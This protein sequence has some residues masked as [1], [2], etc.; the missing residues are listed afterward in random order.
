MYKVQND[1]DAMHEYITGIF[2][3]QIKRPTLQNDTHANAKLEE[4]GFNSRSKRLMRSKTNPWNKSGTTPKQVKYIQGPNWVPWERY[5]LKDQNGYQISDQKWIPNPTQVLSLN[6]PSNEAEL[7]LNQ[8]NLAKTKLEK[9]SR[10]NLMK[11][12]KINYKGG[13][14]QGN[15]TMQLEDT[16]SP[17]TS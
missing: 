13:K 7:P 15:N 17:K 5:Q 4:V 11:D 9:E 10:K 6:S 14:T 3:S 8:R 16:T 12:S 1:T 2:K